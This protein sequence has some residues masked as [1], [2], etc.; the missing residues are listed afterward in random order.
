[1]VVFT[2]LIVQRVNN[3]LYAPAFLAATGMKI[4]ALL[5]FAVFFIRKFHVS[6]AAFLFS[7]FYPYFLTIV[8]EI[9]S[10]LSNLRDQNQK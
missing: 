10:L 5:F 7:F 9:Y 4:L 3:E 6:H 8:F 1:M 2:V